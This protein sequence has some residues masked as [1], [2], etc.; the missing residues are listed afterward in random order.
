[1]INPPKAGKRNYWAND[2]L[3][4]KADDWLDGAESIPGSWWPDWSEW[5]SGHAGKQIAAPK[6]AGSK[7]YKVIEPAP[8]RYVKAKA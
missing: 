7:Q 4:A 6:A 1:M 5:L 2:K 8:G 3:P